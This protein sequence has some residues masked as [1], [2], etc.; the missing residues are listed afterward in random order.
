[1]GRMHTGRLT[2]RLAAA[3]LAILGAIG[4]SDLAAPSAHAVQFLGSD[5]RTSPCGTITGYSSTSSASTYRTSPACGNTMVRIRVVNS[6]GQYT[7]LGWQYGG[8]GVTVTNPS[9][10]TLS[11]VNAQH[12]NT[13]WTVFFQ[14]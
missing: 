5:S 8:S 13:Q 6:S 11:I 2:I 4:V 10:A 14:T 1:M 12:S 3:T 7:W 9:P